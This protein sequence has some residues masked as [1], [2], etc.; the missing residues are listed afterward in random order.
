M[1]GLFA[2][3][4]FWGG[5]KSVSRRCAFFRRR[6]RPPSPR[7]GAVVVVLRYL[8]PRWLGRSC[9][10]SL[11]LPLCVHRP[12]PLLLMSSLCPWLPVCLPLP[13]SLGTLSHPLH[14]PTGGRVPRAPPCMWTASGLCAHPPCC[15]PVAYSVRAARSRTLAH[16][17]SRTLAHTHSRYSLS[18]SRTLTLSLSVTCEGPLA[19]LSPVSCALSVLGLAWYRRRRGS[20]VLLVFVVPSCHAGCLSLP[21]CCPH[22]VPPPVPVPCC[23]TV[24]WRRAVLAAAVCAPVPSVASAAPGEVPPGHVPL[25]SR[26]VVV[27]RGGRADRQLVE[28]GHGVPVEEGLDVSVRL[29]L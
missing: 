27:C 22:H 28:A 13:P 15:L 19:Q 14:S 6:W 21:P 23:P 10:R 5:W 12:C 3:I 4:S 1:F 2:Y 9:P 17:R 16:S 29:E 25:V 11:A 20:V 26:A 24:P 7:R 18:L 8:C